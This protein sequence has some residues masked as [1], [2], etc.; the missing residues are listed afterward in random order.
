MPV[1]I[2]GTTYSSH[3]TAVKAVKKKKGWSD[4][5]ANAYVATVER[6]MKGKKK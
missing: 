3:S 5:R 4:S 2:F 6:N 1:T